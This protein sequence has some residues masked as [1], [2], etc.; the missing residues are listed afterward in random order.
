MDDDT[1]TGVPSEKARELAR[2]ARTLQ[3]KR[4]GHAPSAVTVVVGDGTLVITLHGALTSAEQAMSKTQA[5]AVKVQDFHRQLFASASAELRDEIQRI[6]GVA[7]RESAAEVDPNSGA[8]VHAFTS[9]TM[10]QVFLLA[11]S[12]APTPG[13]ETP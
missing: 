7:V 4:T 11:D 9:G 2:V 13:R 8:I 5:G 12:D 1:K 10:V 6:T 3:A